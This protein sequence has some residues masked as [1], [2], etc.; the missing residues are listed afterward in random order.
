MF[1]T[2]ACRALLRVAG[3]MQRRGAPRGVV[4]SFARTARCAAKVVVA[5]SVMATSLTFIPGLAATS[6]AAI[7]FG[8]G[9]VFAG[10]R[11][12]TIRHYSASGTLLET[13]SAGS[14]SS[15]ETGM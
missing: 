6:S 15:E 12:G 14:A 3:G 13:L 10:L 2:L 7:A 1:R 8:R 11:N 5:I 9:D 4:G